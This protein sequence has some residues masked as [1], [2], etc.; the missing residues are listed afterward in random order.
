MVK[1]ACE[2]GGFRWCVHDSTVAPRSLRQFAYPTL[3]KYALFIA[4]LS[5]ALCS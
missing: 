5:R 3:G 1:H 4:M 2:R